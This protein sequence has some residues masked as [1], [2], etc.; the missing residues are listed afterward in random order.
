MNAWNSYWWTN[1]SSASRWW[2]SQSLLALLAFDVWLEL[3]SH[4]GRYGVGGFNV[5]HFAWLN[6]IQPT[7]SPTIYVG[8]LLSVGLLA[9]ALLWFKAPRWTFALLT[10]GYTW[11]WSMS[12]LDS[13][14]H[15]YMISLVLLSLVFV[16]RQ[17]SNESLCAPA[18]PSPAYVMIATTCSIVYVYTALA[19]LDPDWRAGAALQ[20]LAG[21]N[22]G[23]LAL[24]ESLGM[25]AESFWPTLA[26][27]TI[28]LQFLCAISF[29]LIT[30]RHRFRSRAARTCITALGLAPLS[31]HLGA[32]YLNLQIGWFSYYMLAISLAYFL[33]E[34]CLRV[35]LRPAAWLARHAES[36]EHEVQPLHVGILTLAGIAGLW[37]AAYNVDLPGA[38]V[39]GS[40]G[41]FLIGAFVLSH[42][43]SQTLTHCATAL[44]AVLFSGLMMWQS[45]SASTVRF[46][47]YRFVGGD[48][49]RRGQL[50]NS[51]AAYIKANQYAPTECA[52]LHDTSRPE[53]NRR[54]DR[55]REENLVRRQLQQQTGV[56]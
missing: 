44:C 33:P 9:G 14:Q 20:R 25:E 46:D 27:A 7:P 26:A 28:A 15:H 34:A 41:T 39:S 23:L 4:G 11:S 56:Q 36:V 10:L 22:G 52:A 31:F 12:M 21:G 19:K 53:R 32:E 54:C 16:R 43:R 3:P 47:Y 13:Y 37:F 5:A 51:L 24:R 40:I 35:L 17:S 1:T 42:I 38:L 48:M 45:I 55:R 6:A 29:V 30:Q 50:E 2:L 49:R 8:V 18:Q